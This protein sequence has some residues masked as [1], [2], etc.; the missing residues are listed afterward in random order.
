MSEDNPVPHIVPYRVHLTILAILITLTLTSVGVTHIEL[1]AVT[2]T[3]ALIIATLKSSFVLAYFMHLKFDQRL[4][5]VMVTGVL[6][7]ISVVIVITF[8]DYLYR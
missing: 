6:T 1:G 5:S 4:F 2:V 8:L 7:L 3:V